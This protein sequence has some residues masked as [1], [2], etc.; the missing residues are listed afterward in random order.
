M[1]NLATKIKT[2]ASANISINRSA[3]L[4][5]I[6]NISLATLLLILFSPVMLAIYLILLTTKIKNPIFKQIRVGKDGR[7]FVI[8]KFQT[9][10]DGVTNSGPFICESY[11]DNRITPIGQYLRRKKLDEIPQLFN[12]LKGDMNFV[13]PRPEIPHFHHENVL[14]IPNWADR[15]LVKPGITGPA[16]IHPKVSH[17]PAEK[18][19][20]DLEYINNRSF[21]LDLKIIWKTAYS[22]LTRKSL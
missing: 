20:L 5:S 16:Q 1:T 12:I 6:W 3:C 2:E 10:Y 4:R 22:W 9:M 17:N 14:K 18:I 11:T 15:L 19:I 7:H 13:G 8:Y 21:L